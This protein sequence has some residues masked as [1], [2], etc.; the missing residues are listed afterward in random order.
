LRKRPIGVTVVAVLTMFAALV[1]GFFLILVIAL[2]AVAGPQSRPSGLPPHFYVPSFTA[3]LVFLLSIGK[4]GGARWAWYG[5][6]AFWILCIICFDGLAYMIDFSHGVIF[7]DRWGYFVW[8][9]FIKF[10]LTLIPLIYA[11]G[12]IKYFLKRNFRNYFLKDS[13]RNK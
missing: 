4:F 8:Y 10:L 3:L 2:S 11:A 7:L 5:S 1:F 12:C 13:P 6:L 9:D